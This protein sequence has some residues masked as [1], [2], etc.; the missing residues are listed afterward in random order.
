MQEGMENREV[1]LFQK[2]KVLWQWPLEHWCRLVHRS[3]RNHAFVT[4][5]FPSDFT[6]LSCFN[7]LHLRESRYIKQGCSDSQENVYQHMQSPFGQTH[8]RAAQQCLTHKSCDYSGGLSITVFNSGDREQRF[9]A[10]LAWPWQS[11]R[12]SNYK[13]LGINSPSS[14][15]RSNKRSPNPAVTQIKT[16]SISHSA[17][18]QVGWGWTR[19]LGGDMA[20]TAGP[21]WPKGYPI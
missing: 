15:K 6:S 9:V 21:N 19:G 7:H 13:W 3:V 10:I 16:F 14:S 5:N 18:Q 4:M 1:Q 2:L 20:R 12:K 8:L 11:R 17:P